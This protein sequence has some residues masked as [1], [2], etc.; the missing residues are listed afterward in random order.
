VIE[1]KK[2]KAFERLDEFDLCYILA[3]LQTNSAVFGQNGVFNLIDS[4]FA[5]V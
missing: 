5:P 3:Y 4:L 1:Q 2:P